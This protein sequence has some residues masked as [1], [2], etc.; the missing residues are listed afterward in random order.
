LVAGAGRGLGELPDRV[1]L[2][3]CDADT[4][5]GEAALGVVALRWAVDRPGRVVPSLERRWLTADGDAW[6]PV[7]GRRPV[8]PG[9]QPWWSVSIR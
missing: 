4:V 7:D 8:R 5:S 2:E 3:V 9:A 1:V 6:R